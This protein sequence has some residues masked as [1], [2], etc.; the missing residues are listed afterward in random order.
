MAALDDDEILSGDDDGPRPHKKARYDSANAK[1]DA[2][3]EGPACQSCRRKK[4][5]TCRV[6]FLP[7]TDSA[8]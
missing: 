1:A 7:Y 2:D 5:G 6:S 8:T 3:A 4:V